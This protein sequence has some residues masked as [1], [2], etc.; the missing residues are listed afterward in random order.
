MSTKQNQSYVQYIEAYIVDPDGIKTNKFKTKHFV[1]QHVIRY[2]NCRHKIAK[3]SKCA[4]LL[5]TFITEEMDSKN[6]IVHTKLIRIKFIQRMKK[7]CDIV[8][9]E[10][11]VKKAFYEI[12]K[13]G[14]VIDYG[15]NSDYTV[16]PLHFYSG[17]ET[18][19]KLLIQYLLNHIKK[20]NNKSNI[21][22]ALSE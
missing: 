16:N 19:R 14:L 7:E 1:K 2:A 4:Y 17:S 5:L 9:Q 10:G 20:A 6:N 22:K 12:V 21:K 3:L 18:N 11:T 13:C 8:Y 15:I